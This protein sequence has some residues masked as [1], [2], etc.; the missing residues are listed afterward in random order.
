MRCPVIC[1]GHNR[2]FVVRLF[3]R[4]FRETEVDQLRGCICLPGLTILKK[5]FSDK[6]VQFNKFHPTALQ[7]HFFNLQL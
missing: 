4:K 5:I 3:L 7:A 1:I 6:G 2:I